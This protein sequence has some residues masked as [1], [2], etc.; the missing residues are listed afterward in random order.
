MQLPRSPHSGA[1]C[2]LANGRTRRLTTESPPV[3]LNMSDLVAGAVVRW[4]ES[5]L[6]ARR[7][8]WS[9]RLSALPSQ[10]LGACLPWAAQTPPRRYLV[11][12]SLPGTLAPDC[13]LVKIEP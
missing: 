5:D 2:I 13:G 9:A 4:D 8:E 3:L 11:V 12:A 10:W 6:H 7:E 1:R